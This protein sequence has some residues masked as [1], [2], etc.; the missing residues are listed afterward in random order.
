MILENIRTIIGIEFI[1]AAK[2]IDLQHQKHPEM[3]LGEGTKLIHQQIRSLVPATTGDQ[4]WKPDIDKV[5][6]ALSN[7]EIVL[8]ESLRYNN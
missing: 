4:W 3:I 7:R 1:C 5:S 8:P 2:A 6:K